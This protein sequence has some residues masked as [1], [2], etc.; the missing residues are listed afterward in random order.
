MDH[1]SRPA[2]Q[3][4]QIHTPAAQTQHQQPHPAP[5]LAEQDGYP[6]V[7]LYMFIDAYKTDPTVGLCMFIDAYKT[8]P[9]S[10]LTHC[11]IPDSPVA[12]NWT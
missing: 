7:G 11:L 12:G 9:A 8:D 6:T 5:P 1:T 2:A 3:T 10:G 4:I